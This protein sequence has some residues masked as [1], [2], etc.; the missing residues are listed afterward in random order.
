MQSCPQLALFLRSSFIPQATNSYHVCCKQDAGLPW[1][2]VCLLLPIL[3]NDS[4]QRS[5][6]MD[7]L[8]SIAKLIRRYSEIERLYLDDRKL[9]L[10]EDLRTTMI[11][12]FRTIL[13][14]EARAACQFSRTTAH[15]TIRNVVAVDGWDE[16]LASVKQ[17]DAECEILIRIIGVEDGRV[18]N[19]GLEYFLKNQDQRVTE[20]LRESR[21][22][23]KLFQLHFL[24]ELQ[25]GR[26]EFNEMH[27]TEDESKC[28]KC[29]RTNDYE[30]DKEKNPDKIPGTCEWFLHHP[31]YRDWL[32]ATGSS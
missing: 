15:Q 26:N 16:I 21:K 7:G 11:K 31:R 20:L 14:F 25:Q 32:D 2:G 24:A 30:L 9:R 22:Q 4:K 1:A 5:A 18:R 6:A 28:H 23:D 3:A 29:L 10:S 19:E 12:L 17:Y 8:E 27:L 13:E